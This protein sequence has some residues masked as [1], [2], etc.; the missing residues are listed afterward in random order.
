[1]VK[2]RFDQVDLRILE[3]L[4][5][6]GRITNVE[7]AQRAGISAPPC[8]RRMRALEEA[9]V[10]RGYRA[11]LDRKQL[12]FEVMAFAMVGLSSQA[13]AD[14]AA[15]EAQARAWPFVRECH[16]LSGEVDFMLKCVAPDLTSFQNFIIRDLTA[17]ENVDSVKTALVIRES[18]AEPI[19]PLDREE[20]GEN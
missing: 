4:Q 13:E 19:V 9:G 16:M 14:L 17:A 3:E 18:S 5:N 7:L 8:L 15:F 12:G 11:I 1:M 10:I 6:D 20:M 2:N